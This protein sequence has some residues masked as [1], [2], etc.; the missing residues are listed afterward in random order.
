MGKVKEFVKKHK[1]VIPYVIGAGAGLLI[2]ALGVKAKSKAKPNA[3]NSHAE[4]KYMDHP[5][6]DDGTFIG[7]GECH[8]EGDANGYH[9][10][11]MDNVPVSDL[12]KIG[13]KLKQCDGIDENS[14]ISFTFMDCPL[15]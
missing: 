12:G 4:F 5:S 3:V 6:I 13:D 10:G 11:A 2:L 7:Y 14:R 15:K 1:D 8:D 9:L